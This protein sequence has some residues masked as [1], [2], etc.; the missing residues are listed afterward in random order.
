MIIELEISRPFQSRPG[1]YRS[2]VQRR[3]W[4]GWFAVALTRGSAEDRKRY[5][6]EET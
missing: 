5:T 2:N 1:R 4:W 6:W 3:V